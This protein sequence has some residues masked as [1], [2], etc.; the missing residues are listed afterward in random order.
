MGRWVFREEGQGGEV[1]GAEPSGEVRRG[2]FPSQSPLG[3]SLVKGEVVWMPVIGQSVTSLCGKGHP[4]CGTPEGSLPALGQ[5]PARTSPHRL[6]LPQQTWAP[7]V[8][9]SQGHVH[10]TPRPSTWS[11]A[12]F[13]DPSP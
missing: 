10:V 2:L 13:K 1:L 9:P 7:A 6:A 4:L 11:V 8:F 12:A 3:F 5:G